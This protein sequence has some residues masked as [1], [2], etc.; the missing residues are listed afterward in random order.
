MTP[1]EFMLARYQEYVARKLRDP[2]A[3]L[4]TTL[5]LHPK[6]IN[7]FH[8]EFGPMGFR[9]PAS[10]LEHPKFHWRGYEFTF[11]ADHTLAPKLAP[12]PVHRDAWTNQPLPT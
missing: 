2:E 8:V 4:D 9:L 12:P 5:H 3:T 6:D 10:I 1:N 11:H 7:L